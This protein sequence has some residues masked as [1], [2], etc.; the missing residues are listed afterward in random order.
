MKYGKP[1]RVNKSRPCAVCH[2]I[3]WCLI[4]VDGRIAFCTRVQAGS[5]KFARGYQAYMHRLTGERVVNIPAHLQYAEEIETLRAPL[6]RRH[7][8]YTEFLSRLSLSLKDRHELTGHR[9]LPQAVIERNGYKSVVTE[10]RGREIAMS[11]GREM[12]LSHVPGFFVEGKSWRLS[13]MFESGY[14]IP[15]RNTQGHIQALAMR[16]TG[17]QERN[18]YLWFS[19]GADNQGRVRKLGAKSG[20]PVHAVNADRITDEVLLIEGALKGD[21]CGYLTGKSFFAAS[22]LNFNPTD[23]CF[24]ENLRRAYP[25]LKTALLCFDIDAFE[26]E[27]V[28][29][30]MVRL[31]RA[32]EKMRFD[33]KVRTWLREHK[34]YDNFLL[35]ESQAVEVAA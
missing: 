33:V 7:A 24:A 4:S 25:D 3:D 20:S 12:D 13:W 21:I 1:L 26:N 11:M 29:K 28:Y 22:G 2:H 5:F 14:F 15:I 10:T 16:R 8:V 9:G 34:G 27:A 6:A 17:G 19:S 23:G 18:K 35:S 32:L 31:S 30:A